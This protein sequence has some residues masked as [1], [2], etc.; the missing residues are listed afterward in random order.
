MRS[1]VPVASFLSGGLDSSLITIT[2]QQLSPVPMRTF[3]M[4]F[5]HSEFNE[6][7]YACVRWHSAPAHEHEELLASVQDAIEKLPLLLWHMDEPM[8]DSSII[9]NYLISRMAAQH[10]KVCLSGLG[11][12]SFLAAI[13][14]TSTR[15]RERSASFF[16]M[17]LPPPERSHRS[18]IATTIPGPKS[19]G[20]RATQPMAW[21][22]YL[23]K[24]QIFDTPPLEADRLPGHRDT[25]KKP[26]KRSGENIPARIPCPGANSSTSTPICRTR[27][28][29]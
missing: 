20:S 28:S 7:P 11:G 9:P 12:M 14:A 6:L 29:R 17:R 4:G 26:S 21:R 13:R 2:A 15:S 27:F 5:E 10:V 24:L 8:G 3:A 23:H 22:S 1:D 25:P 19:F 16:S 18:S